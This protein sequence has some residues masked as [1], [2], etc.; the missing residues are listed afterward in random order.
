LT[1]TDA[2][3]AVAISHYQQTAQLTRIE[4]RLADQNGFTA[5]LACLP[6][7]V[8]RTISSQTPYG[9]GACE[10][11]AALLAD[12]ASREAGVVRDI[13]DAP[14]AW[15]RDRP[16]L[17]WA[18][19]AEF[20]NGF[21]WSDLASNC[22]E[23]AAD[24]GVPGRGRWLAL[25]A[26]TATEAGDE[27]RASDLVRRAEEA[28]SSVEF[29][30]AARAAIAG[31]LEGLRVGI[32]ADS[33]EPQLLLMAARANI[34][35]GHFDVAITL[36][37]RTIRLDNALA[38]GRLILAEAL[39]AR[40][41]MSES[42]SPQR[43]LSR[44]I[45]LCLE[46]RDQRRAWGGPSDQAIVL[47]CRGSIL[48]HDVGTV[49]RL[50]TE[51]PGGAATPGEAKSPAVLTIVARA[52]L[53]VGDVARA[54]SS[55]ALLP[56]GFERTY[57]SAVVLQ[58]TDHSEA[59]RV[60][61]HDAY[62]L[63]TDV[64]SKRQVQLQLAAL[65]ED[66]LPDQADLVDE[67]SDMSA[68]ILATGEAA[69]GE[70][71]LAITRLRG[72]R[73]KSQVCAELLA[74]VYSQGGSDADSAMTLAEAGRRFHDPRLL[75]DAAKYF[76]TADQTDHA[77]GAAEEALASLVQPSPTRRSALSMLI[78]L[79]ERDRDWVRAEGH[80]RV[81]A[82]DYP[83]DPQILW[84]LV[85]PL[86]NAHLFE[87]AWRVVADAGLVPSNESEARAWIEL[88]TRYSTDDDVV[89]HILDLS[90]EYRSEEFGAAVLG[91]VM[92]IPVKDEWPPERIARYQAEADNFFTRF[93]ESQFLERITF[94][95][96]EELLASLRERLEPG[97]QEFHDLAR[98]V[99]LLRKPYLLI[100]ASAR[101]PYAA[102]FLQ[103]G[104]GCLTIAVGDSEVLTSEVAVARAALDG[105]IVTDASALVTASFI[106]DLWPAVSGA[107][108]RIAL[109][110]PSRADVLTARDHILEA[111]GDSMAWDPAHS[112]PV[113][114]AMSAE[115]LDGLRRRAGWVAERALELDTVAFTHMSADLD[116]RDPLLLAAL[117]PVDFAQSN[118][119]VLYCDDAFLRMV[120]RGWGVRTF[121]TLAL[122]YALAEDQR[123]PA[124][125]VNTHIQ[126][127]RRA[128]CIDLPPDPEQILALAKES[129][130]GAGPGMFVFSRPA[131]W[132]AGA[133]AAALFESCA[134]QAFQHDP[135]LLA[136][137][138]FTGIVGIGSLVAPQH[139]PVAA[140]QLL[141]QVQRIPGRD[142]AQFAR[143][144]QAAR[145]ATERLGAADPTEAALRAI[146][147]SVTTH[148][149]PEAGA[150]A[151][152]DMASGLEGSAREALQRV[153]FGVG[154]D[155]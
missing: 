137:W 58:G 80:A 30:L 100:A 35:L 92:R 51:T 25:A 144:A 76:L 3:Y 72:W 114:H 121:G 18:A 68:L 11:L 142:P 123:I 74:Q 46:A 109:L 1:C 61:L 124:E 98:D 119:T 27:M 77:A 135:D 39:Q 64:P 148:L 2:S 4:E 34:L 97:A 90:A 108:R 154:G 115:E 24:E 101:R 147:E 118:G 20:A 110:E 141:I 94:G 139:V 56:E 103:R 37:E 59:A 106:P 14:P 145:E 150:R 107:F 36:A 31:D 111:S 93:P 48:L 12:P 153:V 78:H 126:D 63:A 116:S 47:A 7:P 131:I 10:R 32:A 38:G 86:F 149:G 26:L 33:E 128:Y 129:E 55:L 146:F 82:A 73:T 151:L 29:V 23:R 54:Q 45:E 5:N 42:V 96:P 79:A 6:A 53:S 84:V 65:S 127:L 67:G 16:P 136:A 62:Q 133:G 49:F 95:S 13:V 113:M 99:A 155:A 15:L 40:A 57:L 28:H 104:A 66:P 132:M 83:E 41:L 60:A 91:A 81:L 140:A 89:D 85:L 122:M 88:A 70:T 21:G 152:L 44:S 105:D 120:A 43:D 130:W 8:A 134:S 71:A 17:L 75:V 22:F 117:G 19:L 87:Q 52:A 102:A 9:S 125:N 143:L 138:L 50:A 69:R 112:V